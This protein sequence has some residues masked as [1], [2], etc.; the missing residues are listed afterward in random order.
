[1]QPRAGREH[2]LL[3]GAQGR[4]AGRHPGGFNVNC[5]QGQIFAVRYRN[6]LQ[7][8]NFADLLAS[9]GDRYSSLS[10]E[11]LVQRKVKQLVAMA[12]SYPGSHKDLCLKGGCEMDPSP[13][14]KVLDEWPTTIV[15]TPG[16]A[17]GRF[18]TGHTLAERTPAENPVREAYTL[19]FGK[20]G[21][22]RNSWDL[23]TVL[24]AVRGTA[25]SGDGTYF[26]VSSRETLHLSPEGLARS[27]HP[28]TA[29]IS[30]SSG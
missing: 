25:F 6:P 26:G 23:C 29:A 14:I 22:G 28:A 10:G 4:L 21:V 1:V 3:R 5:T 20:E 13:A 2:K 7:Q 8:Q 30:A 11:A 17:C 12:G 16:N 15:F 27:A 19:F 18:V 24:F 9:P